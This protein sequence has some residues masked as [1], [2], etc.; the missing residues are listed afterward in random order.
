MK[1]RLSAV[2]ITAGVLLFALRR[3][4]AYDFEKYEVVSGFGASQW[5]W[6]MVVAACGL[7]VYAVVRSRFE[8]SAA[9]ANVLAAM[10]VAATIIMTV[11]R[12]PKREAHRS[13][14]CSNENIGIG[15]SFSKI[16][17]D[18]YT[19]GDDSPSRFWLQGALAAYALASALAVAGRR[20]TR[21]SD[22]PAAR[23]FSRS[24]A[25]STH[26]R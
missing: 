19:L 17:P 5:T 26:H 8:R 24:S 4:V 6:L 15:C 14:D 10:T 9:V 22:L 21:P 20:T 25:S 2:A 7:L 3:A 12:L 18:R 23:A 16:V 11:Q 1:G 13:V